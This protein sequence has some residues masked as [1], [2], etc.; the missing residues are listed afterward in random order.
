MNPSIQGLLEGY[1]CLCLGLLATLVMQSSTALSSALALVAA[2]AGDR[3]AGLHRA[4]PVLVGANIG[5]TS[6]GLLAALAGD[7]TPDT[8]QLALCHSFFN[9]YGA[10]LFYP[11]PFMRFPLP[12]AQ[13]IAAT[14]AQ[15]R[16]FAV[17]YLLLVFITLPLL[18]LVL[19]FAGSTLFSTVGVPL[20]LVALLL[21]ALNMAQRHRPRWLPPFLRS[22][23]W[24]PLWMHS[25]APLDALLEE[26]VLRRWRLLDAF[27]GP[28]PLPVASI[29]SQRE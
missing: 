12:L 29:A 25:L 1:A 17:A 23:S 11:V 6:T 21:V 10:L 24:L 22:W 5:T 14:A 15:Y 18:A 16:W 20:L 26:H 19:S 27:L 28:P 7:P 4:Y 13:L 3:V 9:V 8:L 2:S